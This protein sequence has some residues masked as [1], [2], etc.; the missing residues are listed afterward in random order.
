[1]LLLGAG[2]WGI[3]PKMHSGCRMDSPSY[4][5][6]I[7]VTFCTMQLGKMYRRMGLPYQLHHGIIKSL[8][9][10]ESKTAIDI[11]IKK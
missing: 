10:P 7:M 2:A 9:T 5:A 3:L 1:M 8:G 6:E 11:D 4:I